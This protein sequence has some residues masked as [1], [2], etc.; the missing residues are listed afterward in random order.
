M[1]PSKLHEAST[2][3]NLG[4]DHDTL[5]I[6][7]LSLFWIVA[8]GVYVP[9]DTLKIRIVRSII[10]L[11]FILSYD[12]ILRYITYRM[13]M[14]LIYNRSNLTVHHGSYHRA[15]YRCILVRHSLVLGLLI[16]VLVDIVVAGDNFVHKLPMPWFLSRLFDLLRAVIQLYSYTML[17]RWI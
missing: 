13:N 2:D 15:V 16:L 6:G 9:F 5:Q 10:L 1:D 8:L 17:S 11:V 14:W 4:W 3:P 7:P 12:V